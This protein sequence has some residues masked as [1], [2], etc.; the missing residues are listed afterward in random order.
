[1][2]PKI[3]VKADDKN[4]L[5]MA[6]VPEMGWALLGGIGLVFAVVAS[7][8]LALTLYPAHFDT[9]EWKFGTV[10]TMFASFP[11]FAMG[12]GLFYGAAVA[13]GQPRLVRFLS[14]LFGLL[15]LLILAALVVYFTTV[16]EAL[17]VV[18]DRNRSGLQRA[19]WR[20]S[21]QGVLY[22]VAFGW[23]SLRGWRLQART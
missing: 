6:P 4:R 8:D 12:W 20:T 17:K 9:G 14:V 13:R 2:T 16:P 10:T 11:L 21:L 5:G 1:M 7:S 22:A 3:L 19:V 18:E 15:A 23:M